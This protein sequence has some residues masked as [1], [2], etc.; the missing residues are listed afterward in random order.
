[1]SRSNDGRP[2]RVALVIGQ[3]T[4]GGAE[5][6]LNE[7]VR[8]LDRARFEPLV[9]SL[10]DT[11]GANR[12]RLEAAGV[13]VSVIGSVGVNRARRLARALQRDRVDLVHAWLFIA[14]T[15]AWVASWLGRRLPLVTS[16]RNCKSQG[17][18]H[19][20]GNRAAFRGSDRIIV[21]SNQVRAYIVRAY[22]A[23]ERKVSVVYNG[24]DT[25]RFVPAPRRLTAAP[26]VITAGRL[27]AQKN[28]MLFLEAAARVRREVP[29]T[30]FIMVGD[31]PLRSAVIERAR[32]LGI[33]E[34]LE[35]PG[36]RS[37]IERLFQGADICWLTSSWEGLPNVVMEAMACGLPVIASDVGGTRELLRSGREGFVVRPHHAEDFAYYGVA[38][39]RDASLRR[40]MG[41]A[42]R[43]RAQQFSVSRMV[44][45]TQA[46]YADALREAS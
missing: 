30:R 36:E 23:P 14:N 16:A 12:S 44:S 43:Q 19:H 31:G 26:A 22:R 15:Y 25:H 42:A 28:P 46:V 2:R 9:Y 27:V 20:V 13:S 3:L 38:L 18:V 32:S 11:P 33:G 8:G 45:S 37:D 6:Q 21:N 10:V 4:V 35:L 40:D 5:G 7:L 17:A 29:G 39:L 24:V 41:A 34:A 1:M